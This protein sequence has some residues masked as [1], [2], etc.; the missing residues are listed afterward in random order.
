MI[1][2]IRQVIIKILQISVLYCGVP[3]KDYDMEPSLFS[4]MTPRRRAND[5]SGCSPV[6]LVVP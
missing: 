2:S 5:V 6:V 4:E 3:E 1:L